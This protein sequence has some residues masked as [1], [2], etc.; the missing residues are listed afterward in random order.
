M[1]PYARAKR[2]S[3]QLQRVL[4]DILAKKIKDPRLELATVTGVKVELAPARRW[5]KN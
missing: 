4:T 5:W 2:V 1:K 3:S